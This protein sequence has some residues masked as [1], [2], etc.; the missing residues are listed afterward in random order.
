M[1]I[2]TFSYGVAMAARSHRGNAQR[3]EAV[4]DAL[5]QAVESLLRE[6]W[7]YT[8]LPVQRIADEA[9]IARSTFYV[10]FVDKAALI[11][12]LVTRV[13]DPVFGAFLD[14]F[15]GDHG[16]G[17]ADMAATFERLVTL[18]RRHSPVLQAILEVASYEPTM[19]KAYRERIC[20]YS[21]RLRTRLETARDAGQ[22]HPDVDVA[23]TTE[24]MCWATE[25]TITQHIV[26]RPESEDHRLAKALARTLWFTMYGDAWC[27][28]APANR[29]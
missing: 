19:G 29:A 22:L 1:K 7:S 28:P 16:Q 11:E 3:R 23:I 17:V 13:F 14:W 6:G 12:Q 18:I 25:R 20:G 15:D 2:E 5:L 8:E 27:P 10:H 26:E 9:G 21:T 24:I 4:E